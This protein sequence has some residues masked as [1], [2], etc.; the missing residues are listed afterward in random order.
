MDFNTRG[1]QIFYCKIWRVSS[2]GRF[3]GPVP[4][5]SVWADWFQTQKPACLS[6]YSVMQICGLMQ[7]AHRPPFDD[8][9]CMFIL[10]RSEETDFEKQ[11]SKFGWRKKNGFI[12]FTL[13]FDSVRLPQLTTPSN[14]AMWGFQNPARGPFPQWRNH[15]LG[16]KQVLI[17]SESQGGAEAGKPVGTD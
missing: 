3:P 14:W 8:H 1:L 10:P 4:S 9:S 16:V 15:H 6:K 13:P 11:I 12:Y 17:I 2:Q 5:R 7:L